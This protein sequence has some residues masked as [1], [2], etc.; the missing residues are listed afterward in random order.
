MS[1]LKSQTSDEEHLL[2]K[3]GSS[4]AIPL[5]TI[6][7]KAAS[8][9]VD[10]LP[11]TNPTSQPVTARFLKH[12]I[13]LILVPLTITVYFIFTWQRY[14]TRDKDEPLKYGSESEI[15]INYSWFLIPV[16]GLGLAK[17]GIVGVEAAMIQSPNWQ[18]PN[19]AAYLMHSDSS[20]NSPEE[21][22][23]ILVR[24]LFPF[25]AFTL[26]GL[27]YELSDG[28]VHS[29]GAPMVIGHAWDNYHDRQDFESAAAK[30]WE[31]GTHVQIP[32]I[33]VIYTPEYLQRRQY[34]AFDHLPNS[35]P[36][37]G[38]NPEIFVAPQAQTPVAGNAWGLHA[39]YNCSVLADASELTILSPNS[40][41]IFD[42][43]S[44]PMSTNLR[45]YVEMGLSSSNATTLYDGTE[46]SS[47]DT[48]GI[49]KADIFE[50]LLWQIRLEGA[51]GDDGL[52]FN[53]TLEPTVKGLGQ[54]FKQIANGSYAANDT[55]FI[56]K[57]KEPYHFP[58]GSIQVVSIASPIGVQ[59]RVVSALGTADLN[60]ARATFQSFKRTPPPPFNQS[61]VESETP[62]FGNIA[63]KTM[64][65]RYL[66]IFTSINSPARVTV[67]NSISYRSFVQPQM[68]QRSIMMAYAMDAL[69]LMYDGTYSFEGAWVNTNLTSSSPGK[70]LTAGV[71]PPLVPAI[72]FGV[73]SFGSLLLVIFYGFRRRWSESLDGSSVFWRGVELADE[74]KDG[75]AKGRDR[76]R[77]LRDLRG[78]VP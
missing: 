24:C 8:N 54:P 12:E 37:D 2:P 7:N 38:G 70:V 40:V 68:L 30:A 52:L 9:I 35:V 1:Q 64:L 6:S 25:T 62:R 57:G 65:N 39:G 53:S 56:S 5:S 15:W 77:V 17:Y 66:E 3:D 59:C 71:V 10:E 4:P 69:Q 60:P 29:P 42:T 74:A 46:P 31:I 16:F 49:S 51:Y 22:G 44:S 67:S 13:V 76:D 32:G 19:T 21:W 27:S 20:W 41:S 18:L 50:Y 14:L 45:A 43:F 11:N 48:D 61:R 33:G 34:R 55:F 26:V 36:L 63:K 28:F 47:F 78:S 73:W 75:L 58:S 23:K 72:G